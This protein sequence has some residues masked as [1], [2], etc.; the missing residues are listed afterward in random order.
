[1]SEYT[2]DE[3]RKKFPEIAKE[4]EGPGTVRI[5]AVRTSPKEAEKVAHSVHGYEPSAVDYI[6]RCKTDEEV[7]EIINFLEKKGDI[8]PEYANRL[9]TQLARGG[10]RSFGTRKNPG[11]YEQG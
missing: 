10:L 7:I 8:E 1:M 6:R 2:K 3:F 4:M 9:R 11:C 5:G